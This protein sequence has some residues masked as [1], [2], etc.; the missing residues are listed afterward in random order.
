MTADIEASGGKAGWISLE[1]VATAIAVAA[2]CASVAF[3]FLQRHDALILQRN[4]NTI[5][6]MQIAYTE[7]VFAA[8]NR[9]NRFIRA[10]KKLYESAFLAAQTRKPFA[11]NIPDGT[12]DDFLTL[13]DFYNTVVIC[14]EAK[15]C[16]PAMIDTLFKGDLCSFIGNAKLIGIPQL[17]PDYGPDLGRNLLSY[18]QRECIGS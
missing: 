5:A 16:N 18:E 7:N 17:V 1:H 2:F 15:S 4:Q 8:K 14:R 10:N 11:V 13:A 6:M 12:L 9:V 3:Y